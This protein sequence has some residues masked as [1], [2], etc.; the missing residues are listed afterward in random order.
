MAANISSSS[1]IHVV[2]LR[3]RSDVTLLYRCKSF[4]RQ[5]ND[6]TWRLYP[7]LSER[8][9]DGSRV[10]IRISSN[11]TEIELHRTDHKDIPW[12]TLLLLK[13]IKYASRGIF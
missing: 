11:P 8:V 2:R 6:L 10:V 3:H 9:L 12:F 1:R 7:F 13:K 4:G 5:C